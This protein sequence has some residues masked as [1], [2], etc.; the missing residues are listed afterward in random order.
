MKKIL[1]ILVFLLLVFPSYTFASTYSDVT[2][3]TIKESP[4]SLTYGDAT[5]KVYQAYDTNYILV[6]DLQYFG[7][8]ILYSPIDHSITISAPTYSKVVPESTYSPVSQPFSLYDGHINLEHFETQSLNCQNHTLIPLA[9][10]G[11]FG[12]LSINNNVC[13]FSPSTPVVVDTNQSMVCNLSDINLSVSLLDIYWDGKAILIPSTYELGPYDYLERDLPA[14]KEDTLYITTLVQSATGE[15]YSYNNNSYLGQLNIPMMKQYTNATTY[16]VIDGYGDSIEPN[17]IASV[18]TFINSKGISSPTPYLVWTN[19]AEQ[20]TYIFQGSF[21]NW[22]L[23]KNFICSTGKDCS[24]TPKGTFSL[25]R[26]VS[27]FGQNKG[28]CCKYAFGFIG[29]TYLYH[30]IIF[31]KTGTYLLENKG[32]LGKKASQG[33]IR[34]SVEN[35]KWFYD[36]MLPGTTVY[37]N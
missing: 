7:S 3:G 1:I 31:D 5:I 8:D 9:S 2:L 4:L 26:K 13:T 16:T 14:T 30:S 21:N 18:E 34:F 12:V 19:I 27:S 29:T 32:V 11:H 10:L 23:I 22:H 28:Y 6:T 17:K 35:A 33:C 25:T 36:H 37:I 20:R 24:P 15:F